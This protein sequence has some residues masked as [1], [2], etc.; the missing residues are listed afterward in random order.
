MS[1]WGENPIKD[2]SSLN[3]NANGPPDEVYLY[4]FGGTLTSSGSFGAAVFSQETGR[5]KFNDTTNPS[6]FLTDGSTGGINIS[7]V[8]TGT[9]NIILKDPNNYERGKLITQKDMVCLHL[10]VV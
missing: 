1:A 4:R 9:D 7:Y 6:S 3:G 8:K 5:T 2:P 10:V